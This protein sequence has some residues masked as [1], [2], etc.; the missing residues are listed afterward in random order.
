MQSKDYNIDWSAYFKLSPESESGLV[1][2]TPRYFNGTPN[3]GRI[4]SNVGSISKT[5]TNKYWTVGIGGLGTFLVH[6]IIWVMLNGTVSEEKDIDHIDGNGLNNA[7]NNLREVEKSINSRNKRIRADNKTGVNGIYYDPGPK[8]N[9]KNI[10]DRYSAQFSPEKGKTLT[11]SFSI[12]KY[13][14]KEAF[15]LALSW[16]ENMKK[17]YKDSY[18]ERNGEVV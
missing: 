4:G 11:K 8:N 3:Y 15:E 14:E 16:L 13:G 7:Y 9:P 18:S 6:R 5:K 10:S 17:L 2:A 1:W 12:R